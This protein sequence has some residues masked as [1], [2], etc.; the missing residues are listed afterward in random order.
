MLQQDNTHG[1][2]MDGDAADFA[3]G[4]PMDWDAAGFGDGEGHQKQHFDLALRVRRGV[5]HMHSW[6]HI[7]R[8]ASARLPL[9]WKGRWRRI[10]RQQQ[11]IWSGIVK[12]QGLC[13]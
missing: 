9:S 6:S 1:R 5:K 2:D 7:V 13:R 3:A 4:H 8:S 10:K 12:R 11:L